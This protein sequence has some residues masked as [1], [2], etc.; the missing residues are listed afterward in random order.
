MVTGYDGLIRVNPSLSVKSVYHLRLIAT[1]RQLPLD[2]RR[3]ALGKGPYLLYSRHCGVSREGGQQRA[4][5]PAQLQRFLRGFARQQSVKEAEREPVSTAYSVIDVEV[6]GHRDM[7][8]AVDPGHRA[9]TVPAGGVDFAQRRRH[10]LD[11]RM[12]FDDAI[13]HSEKCPRIELRL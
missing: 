11:L 1:Y 4:V 12:L 7:R 8:L 3:A 9:P 10:D 13:N 2:A 5:T 6:A